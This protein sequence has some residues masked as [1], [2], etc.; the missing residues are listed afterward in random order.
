MLRGAVSFVSGRG[1][2]LFTE[3]LLQ[4]TQSLQIRPHHAPL[5]YMADGEFYA[6]GE[7]LT[8]ESGPDLT[9]LSV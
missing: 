5:E 6:T 1:M 3:S 4:E 7:T 9:V 8:V 2:D